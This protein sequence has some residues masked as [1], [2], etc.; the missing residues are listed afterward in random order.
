VSLGQV[1][2][3]L[4][5]AVS[6]VLTFF[7]GLIPN[8]AIAIALLT[9]AVMVVLAP[10]TVKSTRSMLAMQKL[11]PEIK[12][13]QQ[14]YK[15]DRQKLNEEMMKVY[16]EN[17]VS[18]V[19]GCLPMLLQLPFFFILYSVVRGL[20]NTV[21]VHGHVVADPKYI[22]HSSKMYHDLVASHGQMVSFG[23]N[24]SSSAT[25][26]HASFAAALPFYIMILVA[27]ALQYLQMRQ[28]TARNPQAAAAN[29]QAQRLQKFMPLIFAF[30]YINIPA[31]VNIYFIVSSLFRIGQQE[32]MFR[33]D[34]V[35]K[36]MSDGR[37]VVAKAREI[38]PASRGK[39]GPEQT[40]ALAAADGSD[41]EGPRGEDG[42]TGAT[43][44]ANGATGRRADRTGANGVQR[45]RKPRGGQARR[46]QN[47]VP[48]QGD[49]KAKRHSRSQS[50]RPRKA[51]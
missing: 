37:T 48:G 2:N 43:G 17:N 1:L 3:P 49:G 32:L 12:K 31:A 15:N 21:R 25:S 46:G 14:K 23:V 20:T 40:K 39:G 27:I 47:G 22:S 28:L 13:L 6:D 5:Q 19:G 10:L 30:I 45:G 51:R 16:K 44:R 36:E 9:I 33:F 50:K 24:L 38:K 35:I 4:F 8:Y 34:P 11:A 41:G 7:Y 29:P 18:P 42:S 26:H